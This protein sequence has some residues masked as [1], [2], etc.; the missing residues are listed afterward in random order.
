MDNYTEKHGGDWWDKI[1]ILGERSVQNVLY[2]NHFKELYAQGVRLYVVYSTRGMGKEYQD[3][4][5]DLIEEWKDAKGKRHK[6]AHEVKCEPTT[7]DYS[8]YGKEELVPEMGVLYA[9]VMT[10]QPITIEDEGDAEEAIPGE[11]KPKPT[12]NY[13]VEDYRNGWLYKVRTSKAFMHDKGFTDGRDI[14]FVSYVPKPQKEEIRIEDTQTGKAWFVEPANGREPERGFP[15]L[16]IPD[17]KLIGF[18][19][20]HKRELETTFANKGKYKVP[21]AKLYPDIYMDEGTRRV[22]FGKEC[23][24]TGAKLYLDMG[25]WLREK[26]PCEEWTDDDLKIKPLRFHEFKWERK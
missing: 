13:I 15:M 1:G 12:G 23:E 14:W 17:E 21:M 26:S 19:D 10:N 11:W 22:I 3:R 24:Q 4:E 20:T 16:S 7:L 9:S 6:K 5:I 25:A 8:S 18:I 2:E